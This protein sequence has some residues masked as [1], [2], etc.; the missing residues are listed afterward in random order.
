MPHLTGLLGAN[1][2]IAST[3]PFEGP[4]ASL[5]ALDAGLGVTGLPQSAT[6]QSVLLTGINI[7]GEIGYHYG[8]KPNQAVAAYLQ[9]GTLFSQIEANGRK[10]ALLNAYP[11]RYFEAIHNGRRLYSAVPLA[12]TNAGLKLKTAAD[13]RSGSAL[14]A[15]FT[16]QGW[17]EHLNLP[18]I[19]ILT[20]HQAGN[21]LGN[22]AAKHDFSFFEYWLS[23][24]AGHQQDMAQAINLLQAFDQVLG[25]LLEIW[26]DSSGLV[27][28][29]SD[30]GNLEDLSTRRH[31]HN[32]VPALTIGSSTLR[33]RFNARLSSLVD[34]S[35]AILELFYSPG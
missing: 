31:T 23:D 25:G 21:Q 14:S 8:P 4:R 22:L 28:I 19:P 15:D 1:K 18:E 16:A 33:R 6:G 11:P 10:T 32:P 30:H 5:V 35:P 26:D 9:N 7:P 13:L 2:L 20:P 34:I 29:T 24:Y 17:H 12:V 3:S 27:L